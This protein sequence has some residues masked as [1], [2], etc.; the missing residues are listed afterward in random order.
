[1]AAGGYA[2]PVRCWRLAWNAEGPFVVDSWDSSFRNTDG[3]PEQFHRVVGSRGF[4]CVA[5]GGLTIMASREYAQ[6]V[7]DAANAGLLQKDETP[8]HIAAQQARLVEG[9]NRLLAY[10]EEHRAQQ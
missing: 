1:M 5:D 2:A 7:C 6:A 10:Y 4:Q 8:A 9:C 3:T